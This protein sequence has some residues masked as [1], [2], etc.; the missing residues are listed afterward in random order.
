MAYSKEVV[1]RFE[2]VLNSPKQF[3]VGQLTKTQM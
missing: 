1:D 2:Q 3:S